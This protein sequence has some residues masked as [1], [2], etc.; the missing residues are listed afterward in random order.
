MVIKAINENVEWVAISIDGTPSED[1]EIRHPTIKERCA[2]LKEF[3]AGLKDKTQ[4]SAT[5]TLQKTNIHMNLKKAIRFIT[6]E[7]KISS[8]NFSSVNFKLATGAKKSLTDD[9]NF[10][11]SSEE[12]RELESFLWNN[13]LAQ[14]NDN[15]LDYLRRC[16]A[17][18]IFNI[19]DTVDGAPI[20]SFYV[21]NELR[22]H[23]PFLFSL[24]D[25]DGKVYPCCHL[26]RDNH[27]SD[28]RSQDFRKEHTL[29]NVRE[30]EYKFS[31]IWN[32]D[33]YVSEREKLKKIKPN[34][35]DFLPCGECTR[36]CQHNQVLTQIYKEYENNPQALDEF[37]KENPKDNPVWF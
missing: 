3:C 9:P 21:K 2:R 16:F 24:I 35:R 11:L 34:D 20:R 27:G 28:E 6:E 4:L 13:A 7:L 17:N 30:A 36:H 22:C 14:D 19:E 5:V 33:L 15:N 18:G 12:L 1:E 25:S 37:V 8:V 23:T 32:G 31:N 10:L 29:G 26:Y